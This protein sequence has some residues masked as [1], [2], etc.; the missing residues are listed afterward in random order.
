MLRDPELLDLMTR[1]GCRFLL[2]GFESVNQSSLNRIAK[3]FNRQQQYQELVRCLHDHRISVQGC[4]VFGFDQDGNDIFDQTITQVH[5]L[6]IDIPRYSI[7]TPYPGT[8]LFQRLES[9]RRI[10]SYHWE[11]YDTMHVVFQPQQ[12]SPEALYDGFKRLAYRETFRLH[13]I[14][15]RTS[16]RGN[17]QCHQWRR[18]FGIQALCQAVVSRSPLCSTLQPPVI[19]VPNPYPFRRFRVACPM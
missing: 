5:D 12:M 14:L 10:L 2:I 1:S 4:F 16:S 18:E 7:Y 8:R 3:G 11:D 15:Q 19:Y 6:K 13:R 9:E 17:D